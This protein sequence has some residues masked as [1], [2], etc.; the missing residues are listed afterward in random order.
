ME[1]HLSKD[2]ELLFRYL[3]IHEDYSKVQQASHTVTGNSCT[4]NKRICAYLSCRPPSR[5]GIGSYITYYRM[6][7]VV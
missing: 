1:Q 2:P 4:N 3:M 5:L 7:F 6:V